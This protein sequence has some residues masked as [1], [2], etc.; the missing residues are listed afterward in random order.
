MRSPLLLIEN[1]NFV[2]EIY[3]RA[4]LERKL[5]L[6]SICSLSFE[7]FSR[8][9]NCMYCISYETSIQFVLNCHFTSVY[10]Q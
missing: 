8:I 10:A 6:F 1:D 4:V 2:V 3:A 9:F 5:W 7:V